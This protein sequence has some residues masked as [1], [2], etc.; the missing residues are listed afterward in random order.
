M[1]PATP[2]K[3]GASPREK[4][5]WALIAT[6]ALGQVVALWMLCNH[7]VRQAQVRHQTVQMERVALQDCLRFIPRTAPSHCAAR[8]AARHDPRALVAATENTA[9]LSAAGSISMSSARL[10][11]FRMR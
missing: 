6:L 11:S 5:F 8:L 10:V 7:Q 2:A 1:L 9:H 4:M 3:N